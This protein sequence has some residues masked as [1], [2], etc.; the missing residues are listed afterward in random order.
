MQVSIQ[1]SIIKDP[2]IPCDGTMR[3]LSAKLVIE[4]NSTTT[5]IGFS[6]FHARSV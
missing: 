4:L 2:V 1:K 3:I 5:K 6:F